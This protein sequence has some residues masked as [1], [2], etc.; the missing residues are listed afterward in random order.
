MSPLPPLA[1]RYG[2]AVLLTLAT[3]CTLA[4]ASQRLHK[5]PSHGQ[6]EVVLQGR[7][8]TDAEYGAARRTSASSVSR[9]LAPVGHYQTGARRIVDFALHLKRDI[10]I[11]SELHDQDHAKL[12][13]CNIVSRRRRTS[14]TLLGRNLDPSDFRPG[15]VLVIDAEDYEMCLRR[16][17]PPMRGIDR[18]DRQ[19]FVA[20]ESARTGRRGA[21]RVFGTV[22]PGRKVV[23]EVDFAVHE[24]PEPE[25]EAAMYTDTE[26][27]DEPH[28]PWSAHFAMPNAVH[29]MA[30]NTS[31]SL[32]SVSR[33]TLAEMERD[34][35]EAAKVKI[36]ASVDVNIHSFKLR[37]LT[38]LEF[39][40]KQDLSA[41]LDASLEMKDGLL[42]SRRSGELV[43][44]YIPKLS[45]KVK[46][47]VIGR[48]SAGGFVGLNWVSELRAAVSASLK[49]KARYTRAEHVNARLLPPRY[50]AQ[51]VAS[52][53]SGDGD[54]T[55]SAS[56]GSSVAV[57]GFFGVRPV[58]GVGMKVRY[59]T[60][61]WEKIKIRKLTWRGLFKKLWKVVKK[62]VPR[63][64][65]K[66]YSI[67]GNIGAD[68]GLEV[69]AQA[70][71]PAF[72]PYTRSGLK[73]GVCD[74]CHAVHG[75]INLKGKNFGMQSVVKGRIKG[76]VTFVSVLFQVRLGTLCA[77]AQTCAASTPSPLPTAPSGTSTLPTATA[78][79]TATSATPVP[80]PTSTASTSPRHAVSR[81]PPVFTAPKRSLGRGPRVGCA[82]RHSNGLLLPVR[83]LRRRRHSRAS[84]RSS[85]RTR[86]Y[87]DLC[88]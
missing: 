12:S 7:T 52:S 60:L 78:T 8:L 44:W 10:L 51:L 83:F 73:I 79:P 57:R 72:P 13:S 18:S 56:Q 62:L 25:T 2:F 46:V 61:Y 22:T 5:G 37:R 85:G 28:S 88:P 75:Y 40:W 42:G 14:L 24:Y 76:E 1:S 69:G 54:V 6:A 33:F 39:T 41:S 3:L 67:E 20:I 58:V 65:W 4:S 29:R 21:I 87:R 31:L 63:W 68:F 17:V 48:L 38:K 64:R 80:S 47:P 74:S 30:H 77:L 66:N 26:Y 53:K 15:V 35:G 19:I 49:F 71:T 82:R 9:A 50:R 11:W 45:F 84:R 16:N 81:R 86:Y 70:K 34:I 36:S 27:A 55:V 23:P 32:P 43:R 59:R